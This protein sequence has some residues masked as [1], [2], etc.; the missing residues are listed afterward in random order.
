[1]RSAAPLLFA[2]AAAAAF[3]AAAAQPP[4]LAAQVVGPAPNH[5]VIFLVDALRPDFLGCYGG[6]RGASPNIDSWSRE[7]VLFETAYSN[8]NWTKPAVASLFTGLWPS[9]TGTVRM[10]NVFPD[11]SEAESCLPAGPET[12]AE[13][14]AS[15]GYRTAGFVNNPHIDAQFGFG[16]GFE[17]FR[18]GPYSCDE[19]LAMFQA[20]RDSLQR[21]ERSFAYIHV[22][23][24]HAPY[25]PRA[26]YDDMFGP[27]EASE[28]IFS[29]GKIEFENWAAYRDAVNAGD[30]VPAASA[31]ESF[32]NLY[33]GE[34]AWVDSAFAGLV[35]ALKSGGSYDET[36]LVFTADHGENFHEHGTLGHPPNTCWEAQI[37]I[38]LMFLFP[39]RWEIAPRR[40][41]GPACLFD[42]T[43]TLSR[44]AAGRP[45][46]RGADLSGASAAGRVGPRV[47]ITEG[48]NRF[49]ARSGDLKVT[50]MTPPEAELRI[51]RIFDV[52]DDPAERHNL[53]DEKPSF[54]SWFAAR[55]GR[56]RRWVAAN[57]KENRRSAQPVEA[58]GRLR[59]RLRALGYLN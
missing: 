11:G 38:P 44:A 34:V 19:I 22:L 7:A 46:G 28:R 41:E 29:G 10:M 26:P 15:E 49:T 37:R 32:R 58:D 50:V 31:I 47:S 55:A 48:V 36:L 43:A 2:L 53:L 1:M 14:L 4:H 45:L 40:V 17:T 25:E 21:A 54:A 57:G 59:E 12:L 27:H 23:E 18:Q 6:E 33:T 3:A 9:E 16:R 56:W 8:A 30:I 42:V 51:S 13:L 52:V 20:W 35:E 5:I 39:S 24:P